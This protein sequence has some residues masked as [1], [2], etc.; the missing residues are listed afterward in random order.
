MRPP[1]SSNLSQRGLAAQ[2]T[3][4]Q[5]RTSASTGAVAA[6]IATAT[7]CSVQRYGHPRKTLGCPMP[8]LRS[9]RKYCPASRRA[10]LKA[11]S[12]L[13][14][15]QSSTTGIPRE[16]TGIATRMHRHCHGYATR[17]HRDCHQNAPGVARYVYRITTGTLQTQEHAP[18]PSYECCSTSCNLFLRSKLRVLPHV[19]QH[20]APATSVGTHSYQSPQHTYNLPSP[21]REVQPWC[22]R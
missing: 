19:L 15:Y 4:V 10:F 3:M 9:P 2:V 18:I 21:F 5:I 11:G 22:R 1:P 20:H 6:R 8:A 13:P 12:Y 17:M 16:C 14:G 7:A